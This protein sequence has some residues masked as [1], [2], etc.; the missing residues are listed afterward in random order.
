MCFRLGIWGVTVQKT[1]FGKLRVLEG[2]TLRMEQ[3]GLDTEA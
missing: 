3:H 1:V 2:E